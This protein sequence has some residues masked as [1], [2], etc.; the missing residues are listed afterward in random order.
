MKSFRDVI[1]GR[2][3]TGK[4]LF[5]LA[6][7]TSRGAQINFGDLTPFLTHGATSLIGWPSV[8][9]D[10]NPKLCHIFKVN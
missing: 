3:R 5:V 4:G 10:P 9:Q 6:S 2:M 8:Q 1:N 7:C